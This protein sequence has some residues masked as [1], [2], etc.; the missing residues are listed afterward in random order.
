MHAAQTGGSP[1][2]SRSKT[3]S[4]QS[5]Q[6]YTRLRQAEAALQRIWNSLSPENRQR[7]RDDQRQ[8]IK[9]KDSIGSVSARAQEVENRNSYL[10]RAA[11]AYFW[12]TEIG[13]FRQWLQDAGHL[14]GHPG[15]RLKPAYGGQQNR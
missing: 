13:H 12:D 2:R 10:Q 15:N 1:T 5:Q 7:L 4:S 3:N 11:T 6:A 8:W 9:R 14:Q